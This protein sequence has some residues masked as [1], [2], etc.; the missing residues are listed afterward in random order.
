MDSDPNIGRA[1][2]KYTLFPNIIAGLRN[3]RYNDSEIA[4]LAGQNFLRVFR[5]VVG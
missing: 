4:Q 1:F 2:E 3:R 5:Q